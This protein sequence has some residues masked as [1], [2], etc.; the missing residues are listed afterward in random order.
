MS[1]GNHVEHWLNGVKI[2]EFEKDSADFKDKLA[3]SKFKD[4]TEFGKHSTGH[5]AF[6]DHGDVVAY[7]NIRIRK[8]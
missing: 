7:R 6:Q 5:I 8:L 3:K 2:V 1:K 4:W